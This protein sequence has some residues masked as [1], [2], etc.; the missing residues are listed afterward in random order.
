METATFG[1]DFVAGRTAVD[2]IIDHC[3]TLMYLCVPINP[4]SYMFGDNKAV[5]TMPPSLLPPSPRDSI[6]LLTTEVEK[7][8]QQA[9][10]SSI[11]KIGNPT[12]QTSLASIR[13]LPPFGFFYNPFFSGEE[14]LLT[15]PP[16]QKRVPG[17]QQNMSESEGS[18]F[19]SVPRSCNE[20]ES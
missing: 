12:L 3:L 9:I 6:L 2:Q 13:D 5:V 15:L 10:S 17:F 1:S 4:K 7:Q 20:K 16:N 11:G 8:L 14:I 19:D 18:W